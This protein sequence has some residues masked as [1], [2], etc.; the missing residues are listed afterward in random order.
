[1]GAHLGS[2]IGI[3]TFSLLYVVDEVFELNIKNSLIQMSRNLMGRMKPKESKKT[4]DYQ[5]ILPL[6]TNL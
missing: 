6:E 1:M 4:N 5:L 3:C 2:S